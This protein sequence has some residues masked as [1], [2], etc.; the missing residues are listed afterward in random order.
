MHLNILIEDN[1]SFKKYEITFEDALSKA[2][3]NRPDLQS[4]VAKRQ[5]AERSIELAKTGYYPVLTGNAG[6]NW[7]E[8]KFLLLTMA[9]M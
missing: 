8:E 7:S 4:I 5:A 1:L 9:G 3:Q 6:Y 2:Y